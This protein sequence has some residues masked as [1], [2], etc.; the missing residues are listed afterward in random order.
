MTSPTFGSTVPELL[1]E[2]LRDGQLVR[3]VGVGATL[4]AG[5]TMVSGAIVKVPV[6]PHSS[7]TVRTTVNVPGPVYVRMGTGPEPVVPLPKLHEY[8]SAGV[9]SSVELRPSKVHTLA[10]QDTVAFATGG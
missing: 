4:P 5:S 9:F 2:Q 8:V 6:A 3:T 7:L 1:T 10:T